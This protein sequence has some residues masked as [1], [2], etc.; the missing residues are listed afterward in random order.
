VRL[1]KLFAVERNKYSV[2]LSAAAASR[3]EADAESK[4]PL[5]VWVEMNVERR[6]HEAAQVEI[7]CDDRAASRIFGVLRLRDRSRANDHFAQDDSE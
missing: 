2:I 3:S 5:A 1:R 4:D 7:P 6:S